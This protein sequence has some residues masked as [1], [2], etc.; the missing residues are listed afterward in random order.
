MPILSLKYG[1]SNVSAVYVNG[2]EPPVT[3]F[4][5]YGY[6]KD[7]YSHFYSEENFYKD[8][9]EHIVSK[10][11]VQK[12]GLQIIATG[13]PD[14]PA[15]GQDYASSVTLD[16]LLNEVDDF[17][18]MY[19]SNDGVFTKKRFISPEDDT[20]A[21]FGR[22]EANYLLNLNTYKSAFPTR[23]SDY[24]LLMAK[25]WGILNSNRKDDTLK[26][27][28]DS[29]SFV[30]FGDIF[31]EDL[32]SKEF[33]SIAYL[34]FV[35][36][37]VNPG[38][39]NLK[40]DSSNLLPHMLHMRKFNVDYKEQ[41]EKFE[42]KVLGTLVNSPGDTSC[43]VSTELGT[44]QLLEIKA[45]RVFFIP[46]DNSASARLVIKSSELGSVER[47]VSGGRLGVI[48]DTRPKFD[49]QVYDYSSLQMDINN[50]LKNIRE[51]L[52]KL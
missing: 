8:V 14:V 19:L 6:S 51:V 27:I 50:N 24:N 46:L 41:Y 44:S 45:N 33:K 17:E 23:P 9:V 25:I 34:Y 47:T 7:L 37:V 16:A 12:E 52:H 20:S 21:S 32:M 30:F 48:I 28:L 22:T 18:Y 29:K 49:L 11:N 5:G 36:M 15:I 13:F 2:D 1:S 38:V 4:L 43:L 10:L 31:H 3:Y 42:P 35:S 26:L 40:I 39:F